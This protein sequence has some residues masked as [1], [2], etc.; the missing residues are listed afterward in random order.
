MKRAVTLYF[1]RHGETDWN[2]ENRL[3]GQTDVPLNETGRGQAVRNGRV[4][5]ELIPHPD[6]V[7]FVASPMAR[8]RETMEIVRAELGLTR[9]GFRLDERLKEVDFGHWEGRRWSE[10]R[11]LDP[12]GFANREADPFYWRPRGGE[13]Y[14]DLARR[15]VAWLRDVERD[16]VVVSHGGVSRTLRGH[17]LKLSPMEVPF[18]RVPQDKV[19]LLSAEG[20]AW[21]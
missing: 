9:N 4:L 5:K 16:T 12:E 11:A 6:A 7:D 15:T 18:L 10:L 3:Q 2:A 17:I 8:T 20:I 13:S 19:L 1:V 21:L 14:A